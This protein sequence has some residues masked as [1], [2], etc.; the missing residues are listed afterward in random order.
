MSGL[1]H[2]APSKHING[3]LACA[4]LEEKTTTRPCLDG[5]DCLECPGSLAC[6]IQE[7]RTTTRPCLDGQDCLECPE[8]VPGC[9][10]QNTLAVAKRLIFGS[11]GE[12]DRTRNICCFR[13]SGNMQVLLLT[14]TLFGSGT[15]AQ[16]V[17][18]VMAHSKSLL[19]DSF[20]MWID[21]LTYTLNII[22]EAFAGCKAHKWLQIIVPMI[23]LST[24][25]YATIGVMQEAIQTLQAPGD[26][27]DDDVNPY[28][29]LGFS[30]WCFFSDGAS[31]FAF[32]RNYLENPGGAQ[33]N[34]TSAFAHVAA[35]FARS[36]TTFIESILISCFHFHGAVT[37][38]W[39]CVIVSLIIL[40][41]VMVAAVKWFK[42][43]LLL[44]WQA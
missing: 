9:C 13:C 37:D 27:Q 34:M 36:V 32:L 5:R 26:S 44:L 8:F 23:S 10:E 40:L 7:E 33:V 38:A 31:I 24:L 42:A 11:G 29:V 21:L 41:G 22:A 16:T 35:D 15:A 4:L 2:A 17:G 28:V 19:A 3:S 18:A 20:A 39:A 12:V 6:A 14:I 1:L 43:V 25:T 30:L